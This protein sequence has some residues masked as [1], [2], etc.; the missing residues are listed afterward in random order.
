MKYLHPP[1]IL[2]RVG[3]VLPV[4]AVRGKRMGLAA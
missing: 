2:L 4:L 1:N 3:R